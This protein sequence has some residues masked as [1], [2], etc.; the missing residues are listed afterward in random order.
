MVG[1]VTIKEFVK[2]FTPPVMIQV[3]KNLTDGHRPVEW[4]YIPEG[5]RYAA[6][7]PEVKGWNVDAI[8]KVYQEKWPRF[9][10]LVED[11]G[12]LGIAHEAPL[13]NNTNVNSHNTMM[14][15]AYALAIAARQKDQLSVLDW[16]GG[17][18]HYYQ[19]AQT[20]LPDVTIEYHCKDMPVLVEYGAQLFPHA[21][22]YTDTACLARTYD[23]VMASSSL[24]YS[25]DW[26][27]VLQGLAKVCKA[28]LFITRLPTV[29]HAPDYVFIQRA[30]PFGYDTEYLGWCLNRTTFLNTASAL[31]L[32][33]VREFIIGERPPIVHA[34]EPCQYRGF[35]FQIDG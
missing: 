2:L 10:A 18:G 4:E 19:L 11:T 33:L 13:M 31:G 27:T 14:T 24:H 8:R 5:W 32:R 35:L 30:Y 16:G 7:H 20:L 6:K 26:L 21:H 29:L 25:E 23:F 1:S 12:P 28:Y 22:F 34:P 3:A 17:I 9:V 15:F